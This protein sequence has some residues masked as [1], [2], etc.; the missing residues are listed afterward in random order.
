MSPISALGKIRVAFGTINIR[1]YG[2]QISIK[3]RHDLRD[4]LLAATH[5]YHPPRFISAAR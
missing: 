2:T 5:S 4:D 1:A 3:P